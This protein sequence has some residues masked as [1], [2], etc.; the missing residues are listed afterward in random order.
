VS[1]ARV[2]Q[3]LGAAWV[4]GMLVASAALLAA[5][6]LPVDRPRLKLLWWQGALVLVLGLPLV[7]P[8]IA[9]SAAARTE[10]ELLALGPVLN[11]PHPA[12]GS[13]SGAEA[14]ALIL[15]AGC[16]IGLARLASGL[17]RLRVFARRASTLPPAAARELSEWGDELGMRPIFLVSNETGGPA[18][19]GVFRPKVLLPPACLAMEPERRRAVVLHELLHV[20]RCDWLF[21]LLEEVL[22]ALFW[23][24]P[25]VHAL[26]ARLRLCREQCVDAAVVDA[27]GGREAYLDALIEMARLS[28]LRPPLPAALLLREHH[29]RARI[30][31]LLKEATMTKLRN[32]VHL[33]GGALFLLLSGALAGW[34]FPLED[35]SAAP[36]A[37]AA[38]TKAEKKETRGAGTRVLHRV[39]A[40]YP[41]AAKKVGIEGDVV[42]EIRIAKS[43]EVAEARVV[44]G[45]EALADAA[46]T[47][48]RQWK[49]EP[50]VGPDNKPSDVTATITMR[51]ALD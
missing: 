11:A 48:V 24:Q 30:E 6:L 33:G 15:A 51:F 5:E 45:P 10:A 38:E 14:L 28:V 2:L 34:S 19:F 50:P 31:L 32:L 8:P 18:T 27:L 3:N 44:S 16:V 7:L 26:V 21:T 43:G 40:T 17:G 41:D 12:L 22:R 9:P 20:R 4:Q 39:D 37:K 42:M 23:F 35:A 13:R 29:L 46:L 25:A 1:L 47:A 36:P 49:F